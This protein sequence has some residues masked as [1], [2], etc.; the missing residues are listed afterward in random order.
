M[1]PTLIECISLLKSENYTVV[2]K[3]SDNC[4]TSSLRGVRPLLDLLDNHGTLRGFC[5]AD[6]VV[7]RAAAY[8]Y[9][10]LDITEL[11]A[12]TISDGACEVLEKYG[13]TYFYEKRVPLIRNRTD[14]DSCPMEKATAKAD[15][16]EDAVRL[17]REA[18]AELNRK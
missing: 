3:K 15:N 7:G 18:L 5:V 9:S 17:I 13:I 10:L 6:K 1:N 16:P 4:L 11:Y 8:I 12:L 14:T 2:L